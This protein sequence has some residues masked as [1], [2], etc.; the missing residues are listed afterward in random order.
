MPRTSLT[1]DRRGR[2]PATSPHGFYGWRMVAL[3]ALLVAMTAPGQT[4]GVSVFVDPMIAEL[5]LTRSQVSLAYLIGTLGGALVLPTVGVLIDRL[6]VRRM[7]L[8]IG[9]GFGV[10]LA[11]MSTV[12]GFVTLLLGFLGIR[13]LGQGSL[14][15]TASTSVTLWFDRRRGLAVGVSS[16][17]GQ[18]LMSLAPLALAAVVLALGW[19]P[20]WLVAAA[21]VWLV[22]LPLGWA[23]RDSPAALGQQLDGD[24]IDP[25]APP[26]TAPSWT[27]A[28]AVRTPM[29][30][31]I[32]AAVIATGMIG[33]GLAF[34]Q[35]SL[36][37]ERGLT[38]AQAAANFIP[39]TVAA[40]GATLLTGVL[41]DRVR[42]RWIIA[43][44][45]ALLAAAM[46]LAQIAAPGIM[47]ILFGM[48]AGAAGGSIRS[49]ETAAFP[50]FFGL[51]SIGSI[52][53]LVIALNV[54]GTAF[55]P[56]AL[57]AGFDR[58]GSY[59]PVLTLLL[60]VPLLIAVAAVFVPVPSRP[61]DTT[62]PGGR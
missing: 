18:A 44:S 48:A 49:L 60:P 42:P 4:V 1:D 28:Q 9:A 11:A 34:H 12:A 61:G 26:L 30:W 14:S 10:A 51:G 13:M 31:V 22:V 45:M 35:I 57:A 6:G 8:V 43:A 52:R 62:A 23:L 40:L 21:T 41:V 29:F 59:G 50:R 46:L 16:A 25:T 39:Q 37:G 53:G 56:L 47:A 58:S 17:I 27:R 38:T 3:S 54:A 20:A 2:Q 7:T 15:L 24:V 36:L 5:G 32:T 19:R 55:G 33:T